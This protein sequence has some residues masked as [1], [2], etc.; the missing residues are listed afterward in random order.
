MSH[1]TD[2]TCRPTQ[3]ASSTYSDRQFSTDNKQLCLQAVSAKSTRADSWK[4]LWPNT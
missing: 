1:L 2:V 4:S 3:K